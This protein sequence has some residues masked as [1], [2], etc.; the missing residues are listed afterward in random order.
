MSRKA[1]RDYAYKLIF[2]YIFS[3]E[4]NNRTFQLF[5]CADLDDS[6]NAYLE[7]VYKGVIEHYDELLD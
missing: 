3:G 1:A 4:P 5:S 6:D 7:K 2:E